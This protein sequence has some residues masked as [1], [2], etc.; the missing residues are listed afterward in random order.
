MRI[1]ENTNYNNFLYNLGNNQASLQVTMQKLS[2]QKEVS[3]PS[4]NPLVASQVMALSSSLTQNTTYA[5]TIKDAINLSQTQDSAL[6]GLSEQMLRVRTLVQASANGAYGPDELRANKTELTS[7][8]ASV[9]DSL[10]AD[11]GGRYVFAGTKIDKAPFELIKA[12]EDQPD[13]NIQKGDVL[14]IKYNGSTTN[15]TRSISSG[16]SIE[17]A[18]NG[19]KIVG[20]ITNDGTGTQ[21]GAYF[22]KVIQTLNQ[23]INKPDQLATAQSTLGGDLLGQTANFA[24]KIVNMRTTIGAGVNRLNIASAQNTSQNLNLTTMKSNVQDV[25][26]AKVYMEYQKD[27]TTYQSTLA[28]GTKIMNTTILNYM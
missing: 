7:V 26:I 19:A 1:T 18:T 16:V 15:Q 11:Y 10:N 13:S 8:M 28:M 25:D 3:K 6:S 9:V 24:D 12:T 2:S 22:A 27:Q 5:N 23:G 14:G 17:L 4:D 20:G 21:L